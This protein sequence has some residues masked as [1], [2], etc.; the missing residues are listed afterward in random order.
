MESQTS[1]GVMNKFLSTTV[2]L[3]LLLGGGGPAR[4][5][6]QADAQKVIEKAIKAQGGAEKLAKYK[7]A[8][9]KVKG[10]FY[11]LGNALPYTGEYAIQAP[12]KFRFVL[13]FDAGGQ[14]TKFIMVV[15]KD[16][17][18]RK[19]NDNLMDMDKEQVAETR[20]GLHAQNVL[21]AVA[22]KEKGYMFAP[23]GE[24]KVEDRPAVGVKVS[25]KG[26]RDVNLYF[27]KQNGLLVK[28]ET[29]VKDE[30]SGQEVK[31]ESFLSDYKEANGLKYPAKL[32]IKRDGQKYVEAENHDYKFVEK[33]DDSLFEKP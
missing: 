7:A 9:W 11:G 6:D 33:L 25:A 1:G 19:I 22:L 15:N 8:T 20:E 24:V 29:R 17:G 30:M 28:V 4:G 3:A 5:D 27:D 13:E 31:Q 23:L 14:Q 16:K 26:Y 2:V 32:L 10:D 21:R 12:D 18:W